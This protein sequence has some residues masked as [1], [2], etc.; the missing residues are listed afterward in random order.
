M[1]HRMCCTPLHEDCPQHHGHKGDPEVTLMTCGAI[2]E[3]AQVI[4][5]GVRAPGVENTSH[6]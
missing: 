3:R 5:M 1:K 2:G 4:L 6:P